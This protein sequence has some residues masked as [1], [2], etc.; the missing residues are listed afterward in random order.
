M[1][2]Y[3]LKDLVEWNE[4]IEAIARAAGLD[5]Y[6]QEFEI[7]D[8]EDMLC[9][10]AYV[11]MPS[12]YPHWSFGKAYDR[13]STFYKYN[14]VGLPYEMVIN[15]NPC[16]AY[17]MKDNSLLLQILTM[18]HVYGH[19]DFFKNNRLFK[20]GTRAEYT[21]E[22][23]KNHAD[24]VRS[25]I[26]DPSIGYQR[27]ERVLDAAHALR[28]QTTRVIGE[29]RISHEEKKKRIL[30]RYNQTRKEH[31]WLFPDQ[32][33]LLP[34]LNKIPLEPDEDLLSFI[35]EFGQLQAWEKD[36]IN[37]VIEE[38]KYFLPQ[39]ETKI[40]NEGWASYWHHRILN[41]LG[42]PPGLHLEFLTRH[43][44]I[45]RP[46]TGGVNPYQIGFKIFEDLVRRFPD[47]PKKIF[48][49]RTLER[50][51]S[52]LR[53]YLTHELCQE[54]NL[55]EFRKK[56]RDYLITEIAD[57]EGWKK[58]RDSLAQAVGLG[59]VP[60]IKVVDVSNKDRSLILQHEYDGRELELT[61]ASETLKYL[62]NLWGARVTL[63]TRLGQSE[64]MLVCN[65]GLVT[66]GQRN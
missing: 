33:E 22:M 10:E 6:E 2:D 28:W 50:D 23:F 57:E 45:V 29:K 7:C 4:R 5:Y 61:Y 3:T 8:Y 56:G 14:L 9:Y 59:N 26:Y 53:R 1:N 35:V 48:E 47:D 37:I 15:S 27:V 39:V 34:D 25:Y 65:E 32:E 16:L 42:L 31:E 43:N 24:R 19:N 60:V 12:R 63:Y 64:K 40:M 38:T 17:L 49:V 55:F 52:F 41:Q 44:L 66:V 21:V 13:L 46:V 62:V 20:Q 58:I 11:G 54:L 51:Q 36:L 30:E 18:A